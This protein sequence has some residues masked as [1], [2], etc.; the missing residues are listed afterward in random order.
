MGKPAGIRRITALYGVILVAVPIIGHAQEAFPR[1]TAAV[2][3]ASQARL[4]L[5]VWS[6]NDAEKITS[7]QIEFIPLTDSPGSVRLWRARVGGVT[8]FRP[9]VVGVVGSTVV[10]LGGFAAPELREATSRSREG[11]VGSTAMRYAVGLAY[12]VDPNGAIAVLPERGARMTEDQVSV[13][14]FWS[15]RRPADWPS[16]TVQVGANGIASVRLTV[17]SSMAW[18]S[19]DKLWV[20]IVYAFKIAPDGRVLQWASREGDQFAVHE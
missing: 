19:F 9:Y 18:T 13:I 1:S 15:R 12:M 2:L 17:L 16:D 8:H 4:E 5:S 11:I 20:P 6:A 14:S 3:V 10:G 7:E